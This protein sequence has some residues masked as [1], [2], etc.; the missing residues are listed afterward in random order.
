MT[1]VGHSEVRKEG[2]SDVSGGV[3]SHDGAPAFLGLIRALTDPGD[4]IEARAIRP[5]SQSARGD[6]KLLSARTA[7]EWASATD[8]LRRL[9]DGGYGIYWSP[10]PRK[11]AGGRKTEDVACWRCLHADLD[12]PRLSLPN[13]HRLVAESGLPVPTA[14]VWTGGGWHVYWR[15][16]EAL[17]DASDW[18]ARAQGVIRRLGADP[19]AKGGPQLLRLPGF[20]N[21][22]PDRDPATALVLTA[23]LAPAAAYDLREFPTEPAPESVGATPVKPTEGAP[24]SAGRVTATFLTGPKIAKGGRHPVFIGAA[25]DL[26]GRG[27]DVESA[28]VFLRPGCERHGLIDTYGWPEL[29]K[30]IR[31]QWRVPLQDCLPSRDLRCLDSSLSPREGGRG[32]IEFRPVPI[33]DLGPATPPHWI[34]PGYLARGHITLVNGLWKAG[35]TTLLGHLLRDLA[36]GGGLVE[37]PVAGK[38]LVV[39]EETPTLWCRRRDDLRLG[40]A[41]HIV[42]RPFLSRPRAGEWEDYISRVAESVRESGYVLV[43]F[44]TIAPLWPVT[45]ENSAS[46]VSAALMPLRRIVDAGAAL[47]LVHHPRKGDATEGQ[48]SRGS[49]ALPA[50]ADVIVELR[51]HRAEDPHDRRRVLRGYSRFEETPQET[52]LE[53]G[54]SGYRV[55]GDRATARQ[56]DRLAA[57]REVLPE[58]GSGMRIDEVLDALPSPKSGKTMLAAD[59]RDGADRGMWLRHGTGRRNDPHRY[60][61]PDGFDSP[62][63]HPLGGRNETSRAAPDGKPCQS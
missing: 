5:G 43:V 11:S 25:R 17:L 60:R 33:T 13:L 22:K 28:L 38:V 37:A 40:P 62:A 36:A 20:R 59:L 18:R 53:L 42:F 63:V 4:L 44:D 24:P 27:V 10:H 2:G 47:M 15:L 3:E 12:D 50:A 31:N 58:Q 7:D 35:K 56:A 48:A 54:E 8:R 16:A 23:V 14:I 1:D 46:E 61:R 45:D 29:E 34:W 6:C 52:V 19:A 21:T 32:R 30:E 51:R 26:R 55:V 57:I 41:L 49:G 9:N 39:S